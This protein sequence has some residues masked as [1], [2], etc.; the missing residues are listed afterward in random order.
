MTM[1]EGE[2]ERKVRARLAAAVLG[3]KPF[4]RLAS[5]VYVACS[6][7]VRERRRQLTFPQQIERVKRG[8]D[9]VTLDFHQGLIR[10]V[11]WYARLHGFTMDEAIDDLVLMAIDVMDYADGKRKRN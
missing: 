2:G 10:R 7:A 3:E 4:F 1:L 11:E 8:A 5:H 9:A 6:A